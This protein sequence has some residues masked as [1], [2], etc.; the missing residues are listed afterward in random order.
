[1]GGDPWRCSV[2]DPRI[3]AG[4]P[5]KV[6]EAAA[7]GV[8]VV[9]SDAANAGFGG[10]EGIGVIPGGSEPRRFADAVISLLTNSTRH[11][12][13]V[14]GLVRFRNLHSSAAFDVS[15]CMVL[16]AALEVVAAPVYPLTRSPVEPNRR[17]HKKS[18]PRANAMH[19]V[20][21]REGFGG[22][23]WKMLGSPPSGSRA[24]A[25]W[26][27]AIAAPGANQRKRSIFSSKEA[28]LAV[29]GWVAF[30]IVVLI[31]VYRRLARWRSGADGKFK[32]PS[33]SRLRR[34]P[35]LLRRH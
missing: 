14:D 18:E 8:P 30:V 1:M 26:S 24:L 23:A 20:S 16:R 2:F 34:T 19:D 33:V 22:D 21:R 5:F 28:I 11:S 13:A 27:A 10:Y 9:I 32:R 3:R 12:A 6:F 15:V 29:S 4:A 25:P 17:Q 31:Y 7:H 35:V